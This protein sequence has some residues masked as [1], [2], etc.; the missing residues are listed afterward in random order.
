MEYQHLEASGVL[1]KNTDFWDLRIRI[2]NISISWYFLKTGWHK[3]KNCYWRTHRSHLPLLF[4]WLG[5]LQE[6]KRYAHSQLLSPCRNHRRPH[7]GVLSGQCSFHCTCSCALLSKGRRYMNK[8]D[9][10][11][12]WSLLVTRACLRA[13]IP[14]LLNMLSVTITQQE[15]PWAIP[16]IKEPTCNTRLLDFS[17]MHWLPGSRLPAPG[18]WWSLWLSWRCKTVWVWGLRGSGGLVSFWLKYRWIWSNS[19]RFLL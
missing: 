4:F 9:D 5:K 8:K 3:V 17:R 13:D 11:S 19:L 12:C 1:A 15:G 7:L 2:W 10:E 18:A 6:G 16:L 14:M